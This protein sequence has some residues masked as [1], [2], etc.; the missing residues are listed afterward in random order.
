MILKI[1]CVS[2]QIIAVGLE[3]HILPSAGE[4]VVRD[5]MRMVLRLLPLVLDKDK[6]STPYVHISTSALQNLLRALGFMERT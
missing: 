1:S 4:L 3:M 2:D 6:I 5:H